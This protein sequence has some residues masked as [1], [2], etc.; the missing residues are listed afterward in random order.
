MAAS[1]RSAIIANPQTTS[2]FNKISLM[3]ARQTGFF[4]SSFE[5][6]VS[7]Q[8]YFSTSTSQI[9][10]I[11]KNILYAWLIVLQFHQVSSCAFY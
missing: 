4:L 3:E 2:Q 5:E 1:F 8:R 9:V 6:L 10:I 7:M 11:L